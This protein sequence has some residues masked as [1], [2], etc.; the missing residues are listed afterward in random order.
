MCPE[1]RDV[2]PDNL[3]LSNLQQEMP[4]HQ[5]PHLRLID[6]GSALNAF[7]IHNLYGSEGPSLQEQTLEYAAPEALLG[8][9]AACSTAFAK[10]VP[11]HLVCMPKEVQ[12]A[13]VCCYLL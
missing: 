8:R 11:S 12:L 2:K 5:M 10:H 6:F 7:A 13:F 9:Y 4:G 1:C 3:L